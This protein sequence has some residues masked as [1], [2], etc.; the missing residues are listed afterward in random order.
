MKRRLTLLTEII[1]PYR[2]PVFNALAARD[3][4]DLHVIF[5]SETDPSLRQWQVYKSEIRFSYEILVSFRRRMDKYNLLINRGVGSA[6]TR[7]QPDVILCGGYNY[8][9][10]W[11]AARWANR[12]HLPVVLWS[13]STANDFRRNRL[14][15]ELMKSR[16]LRSC[17]AFVVAGQSSHEYL[18]RLGATADK[19]FTAPNAVDVNFFATHAA[20]ARLRAPQVRAR[21]GLPPRY[22]LYAGRL[23][24]Q[25]G[26]FDLMTAYAKLEQHHR[27]QIGLV[28]VGDG[29][30]RLQLAERAGSV[31]PGQVH[32][33]GFL[34]REQLAEIYALADAFVFPTHSDPW[35]LVVNEAMACGLPIIASSV[36]GCVPDLVKHAENGLVVSPGDVDELVAAMRIIFDD[37][38]MLKKFA[39]ASASRIQAYTPAACAEGF[40]RAVEFVCGSPHN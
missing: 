25:K 13:E 38:C 31:Q 20:Q 35:G 40:A 21:C 6:L 23:V 4:I 11:Q 15:M 1:A 18:I 8:L 3:N 12:R 9:A 36:A 29:V 39:A 27:S 16:F 34:Q 17:R 26:V 30:S 10:S 14:A 28:F 24:P 22:F 7:S 2:I 33:C 32:F 19:I 5:L 37:S